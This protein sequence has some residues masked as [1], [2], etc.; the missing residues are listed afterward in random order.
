MQ[1]LEVAFRSF[2]P[3]PPLSLSQTHTDSLGLGDEECVSEEE[4]V[5]L[6][7]L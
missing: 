3:P 2:A 6:L 5:S 1:F 7:R 4:E